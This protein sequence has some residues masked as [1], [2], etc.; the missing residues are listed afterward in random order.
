MCHG[1][2]ARQVRCRGLVRHRPAASNCRVA[3]VVPLAVCCA[4]M[5]P[6]HFD[7]GVAQIF[8]DSSS[9]NHNTLAY[10]HPHL[11]NTLSTCCM[12]TLSC[13]CIA[14]K[15]AM[16]AHLAGCHRQR[17]Q[18][19]PPEAT[20]WPARLQATL[21]TL[22]SCAWK[23]LRGSAF[24]TSHMRT[25]PSRVP[26]TR[27]DPSGLTARHAI[28]CAWLGSKRA[29]LPDRRSHSRALRS[30]EPEATRLL[31]GCHTT[32][33]TSAW[34]PTSERSASDRC[35]HLQDGQILCRCGPDV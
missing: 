23:E 3:C 31:F 20:I 33:S 16:R 12:N 15:V 7:M 35:S 29:H 14:E 13:T 9:A 1:C 10:T 6:A 24:P 32:Q 30:A 19:A 18:S 21:S 4:V 26:V 28:P 8:A 17:Q 5:L 2:A 22:P 11:E 27:V 34:W 25:P